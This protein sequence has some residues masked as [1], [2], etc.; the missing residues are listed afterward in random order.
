MRPPH[1]RGGVDVG[2]SEAA[3]AAASISKE[4][5]AADTEDCSQVVGCVGFVTLTG[6]R[7]RWLMI[8]R[9]MA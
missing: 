7:P 6:R 1:S 4:A 8:Q 9:S 2:G 5:A 3:A